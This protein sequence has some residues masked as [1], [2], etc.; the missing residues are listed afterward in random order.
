[1][2]GYG[3]CCGVMG[4]LWGYGVGEGGYGVSMG[5]S[6]GLWGQCGVV[7]SLLGCG[8]SVGL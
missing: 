4:L 8:I 6:M 2:L 3:V 1:M 5:L 7:A